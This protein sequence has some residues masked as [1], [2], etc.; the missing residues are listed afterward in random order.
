MN[1]KPRKPLK[2]T[3]SLASSEDGASSK[4]KTWST[5]KRGKGFA[6]SP[7]QRAK[8]K[9]RAC[10][11]CTKDRFETEIHPAHV[12]PR[13]LQPCDCAEGVVPLCSEHHQLY[14][15]QNQPFDL[16]P[17]L[18]DR[19]CH[20]EFVHAIAAHQ[21]P[22]GILLEQVTGAKWVAYVPDEAVA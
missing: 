10:I 13:R 15:D 7:A 2:R 14:D 17:Y 1:P 6:A 21:V 20:V 8:V 3:S 11:V 19:G 22:F 4:P 5:L 9:D 18:T 16:L 12:Y